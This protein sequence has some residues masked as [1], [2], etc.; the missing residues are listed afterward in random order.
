MIDK[1]FSQERQI[2]PILTAL[3]GQDLRRI[4]RV[5]KFRHFRCIAGGVSR[6]VSQAN[7]HGA[8]DTSACMV[9]KEEKEGK[10]RE[11]EGKKE[12]LRGG[13][14]AR[15]LIDEGENREREQ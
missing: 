6:L 1:Q 3:L 4:T 12:K 15:R 9:R 7:I 2:R 13:G 11:K 10:G 5:I 14:R 8:V